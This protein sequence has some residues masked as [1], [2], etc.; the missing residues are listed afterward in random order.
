MASMNRLA[1]RPSFQ[2]VLKDAEPYLKA[3]KK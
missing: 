2:P 3:L 1:D